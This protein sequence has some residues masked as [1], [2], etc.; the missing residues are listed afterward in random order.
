MWLKTRKTN[1]LLAS[2]AS[3]IDG[4][5][6]AGRLAGSYRGYAVEAWPHS[7]YPIA[8]LSGS[9]EG[10][11]GPEPV[12]MLRIVLSGATGS[13]YWHCQSSARSYLQDLTSRFTAGRL[14]D[15]FK[16]GEFKFQGVD[17]L[18]DALE[19][20]GEEL[21]KWLEMPLKADA[22]LQ[23]RLIAAGLFDELEA[24]RFGG[25]PY[26]PK[27]EFYPGGQALTET[28][29]ASPRF[30]REQAAVDE[31]LR[32]A[33]LPDYRSLMEQRMHEIEKRTPGRLE[34]DVE[35]GNAAVPTA[36]HFRESLEHAVQIAQLN[37][38]VNHPAEMP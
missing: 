2:L 29:M 35:A 23:Q 33:G 22:A 3:V 1:A 25:H 15:R 30:A 9:T 17:T 37:T 16:P 24:L 21:T 13:K 31:R 5:I 34:L 8:Y 32:A 27:V 10:S 36:E 6:G 20:M 28:Y 7:G 4:K 11:V 26:L 38:E 12:N 18:T 19:H 14:L